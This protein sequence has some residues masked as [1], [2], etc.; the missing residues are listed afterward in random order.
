LR[1]GLRIP[2]TGS[3]ATWFAVKNPDPEILRKM[4]SL[5]QRLDAMVQGDEGE[6]YDASGNVVP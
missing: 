2:G 5:A 4:W 3:P 6:Q 1:F